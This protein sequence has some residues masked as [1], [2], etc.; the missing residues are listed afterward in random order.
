MAMIRTF[1]SG[2]SPMN[3]MVHIVGP[4]DGYGQWSKK[5]Q[6]FARINLQSEPL[7]EFYDIDHPYPPFNAQFV[8]RY[9][10]SDIEGNDSGICLD[11][12][13]RKWTVA[14]ADMA[15]VQSFI[16]DYRNTEQFA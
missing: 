16:R 14:S 8:S 1:T 9:R 2:D 12:G 13:T 5:E 6:A 4:G 7:I 10:I 3:F 11:G 15:R